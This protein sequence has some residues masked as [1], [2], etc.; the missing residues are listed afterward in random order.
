ME[1]KFDANQEYQVQAIEA[2]V[3][4][5]NG[6][7]MVEPE[8]K[9]ELGAGLAAVPND[10]ELT[11]D[12]ILK[13]LQAVQKQNGIK[14]D[15]GLQFIE[16]EIETADGKKKVSF[17]N[18]STE[19][20]TGTGKTYIYIR[21]ILELNKSYGMRKFII[22]VPSIAIREGVLKTL[23][24]TKKH[25]AGLFG[26]PSYRF[27]E[28]DSK[29]LNQVRQF[30]L[31]HGVEIMIMTIDSFNKAVKENS[32]GNVIYRSTDRLQGEIPIHLIQNSR[33]ILIL[34]EPQNMESEKSVEALSMLNPLFALRYS[35]THKNPYNV[36]YRLTPFDAYQQGLVKK[37]E[38]YSVT[39]AD[40]ANQAYIRLESVQSKKT[41][42]TAKVKVHVLQRSGTVKE[43]VVTLD[44]GKEKTN[45]RDLTNLPQ[46][47]GFELDE[48][49]LSDKSVSFTNGI[50]LH[51]GED[52][53]G[54]RET[55]FEA[56]IKETIKRHIKKQKKLKDDGIKILSLFFIDRV[57]NYRGD[58]PLIRRLFD[59]AFN[60]LRDE[61]PEWKELEADQVQ[62]AYFAQ[63]KKRTGEIELLETTTGKNKADAEAYELIM[64][65]K[66][67]LLSFDTLVSFIFSHSALREGWDNPNVFQICTLNQTASNMKKRQEIGRGVRLC[68]DQDGDRHFERTKNILTVIANESYENYV[69]QLQAE[70]EEEYGKEGLPPKPPRAERT[71][72][73]FRK[74][75]LLKPEF[76]ELWNRIKHKTLYSVK[77]DSNA[78]TKD[79]VAELDTRSIA[80]PTIQLKRVDVRVIDEGFKPV[81][82][83]GAKTLIDL[84]GR[85]P[86]PN[87]IEKLL[88]QLENTTPPVRITRKTL[89]KILKKTKIKEQAVQNPQDFT[90]ILVEILKDKLADHIINGIE[91][92]KLVDFYE[93]TQINDSEYPVDLFSDLEVWKQYLVPT[94][95]DKNIYDGVE[96]D[97]KVEKEF[98][99]GMEERDD[100]LLYVKLPDWFHIVTPVGNYNPDWAIVMKDEEMDNKPLL[101]LVKETKGD[102]KNLRPSELRKTKYAKKHFEGALGVPY[103]VVKSTVELPGR[104]A[105]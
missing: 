14:E 26:N 91:Y 1:F 101:Y 67:R 49:E 52:H 84:A 93:Q 88:H 81:L 19:M 51:V 37:I 53:G 85:Y 61:Y 72:V 15:D 34:D 100:V 62:A 28:Y 9:L 77:I 96:W 79:V 69:S 50:T 64:K 20:E 39:R 4:L 89:T 27:Y 55:I 75:H 12:D 42:I 44:P 97:S 11:D 66:E 33:P 48:I 17:P 23:N 68:V 16:K 22:V 5:F 25:F 43:K 102:P 92:F 56:Q 104:K 63:K 38:V 95:E 54:D 2:V 90:R 73:K 103:E 32:K 3:N 24:I 82:K 94:H 65:D 47:E 40:E 80:K 57:D 45:L 36:V 13:N 31:G 83:S 76:K 29:S 35:A 46:Y 86:L 78:L 58:N 10:L 41:S 18:F 87:L 7:P 70:I 105:L 30:A 74:K 98:A 60:E 59:E 99:E 21:T 8:T 6:Q 71:T